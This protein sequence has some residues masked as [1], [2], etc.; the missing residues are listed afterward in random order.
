MYISGGQMVFTPPEIFAGRSGHGELT[1]PMRH[2][3]ML[4]PIPL[5][6]YQAQ[7]RAVKSSQFEMETK[8][9]RRVRV[10]DY[11]ASRRPYKKSELTN[12]IENVL[13]SKLNPFPKGG[14]GMGPGL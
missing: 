13:E 8:T 7:V 12:Y 5:T 10:D 14:S 3:L 2:Q 6:T 4:E 11:H 1:G 9:A